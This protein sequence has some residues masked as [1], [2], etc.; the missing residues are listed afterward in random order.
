MKVKEKALK[1]NVK[2]LVL[3]YMKLV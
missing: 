2:E 1:S 3:D